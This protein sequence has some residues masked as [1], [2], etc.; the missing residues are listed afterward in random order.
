M[1]EQKP[2]T[3][4]VGSDLFDQI[5]P[6]SEIKLEIV[7]KYAKSYSQILTKQRFEHYY[8]DAFAGSGTHIS[9]SSRAQVPGSPRIAMETDPPFDHYFFIDIEKMKTI[10][11][12]GVAGIRKDVTI[13]Q[14]DCNPILLE[15]VF[16]AV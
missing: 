12:R 6:W 13:L 9:R 16:P 14:G 7:K 1:K 15:Q 4:R 5:G 11:L 8:I 2:R 10:E 3:D